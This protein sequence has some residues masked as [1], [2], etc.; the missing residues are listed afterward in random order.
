MSHGDLIKEFRRRLGHTSYGQTA[1]SG[2]SRN[3]YISAEAIRQYQETGKIPSRK[4]QE[5]LADL[6]KLSEA[7]KERLTY[8]CAESMMRAKYPE[9]SVI[10]VGEHNLESTIRS[11]LDQ[12]DD[13]PSKEDVELACITV[14][15]P[16]VPILH[17]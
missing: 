4:T 5:L 8:A 11:I 15:N 1:T 9:L 2:A 10:V 6:L 7:D 12:L 14:L 17:I 13:Q 3:I 16:V